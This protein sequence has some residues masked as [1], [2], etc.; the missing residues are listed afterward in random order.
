MGWSAALGERRRAAGGLPSALLKDRRDADILGLEAALETLADRLGGA[1]FFGVADAQVTDMK[2]ALTALDACAY[3]HLAVLFSI[4]CEKGSWLQRITAR[5]S[6]LAHFCDRAELLL[7]GDVWP[8]CR[9]FLA[10]SDASKRIPGTAAGS[11]F[12]GAPH[13][14]PS[15]PSGPQSAA[16]TGVWDEKHRAEWWE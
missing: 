15:S 10:G 6:A 16:N 1:D 8:D 7:G 4:P 13:S 11:R 2:A 3:G 5:F 9:S 12:M 14:S